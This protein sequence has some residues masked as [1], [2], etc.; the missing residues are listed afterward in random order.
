MRHVAKVL[1]QFISGF[2]MLEG[3]NL[4]V[5]NL[6]NGVD[7]YSLRTMQRIR[8]FEY[9]PTINVPLQVS[10]ARHG[11]DWVVIGGVDRTPRIYD[12]STGELL[13][14][15]EHNPAGRV[16]VVEVSLLIL[17]PGF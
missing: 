17:S 3:D 4:F 9:T 16:Q 13:C 14:R 11:L 12:R 15:L 10:L 7:L 5:H 1:M 8:H 2:S 6:S